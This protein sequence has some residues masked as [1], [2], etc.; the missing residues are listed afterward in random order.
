MAI[1]NAFVRS[2]FPAGFVDL[3]DQPN[4][5][6]RSGALV[7]MDFYTKLTLAGHC[8]QVRL[9]KITTPVTGDGTAITDTAAE[10]A[11]DAP[12]ASVLI[13]LYGEISVDTWTADDGEANFQSV[14]VVS[15]AGTAFT[16]LPLLMNGDAASLTTAR[17]AATGAVTVTAD[18]VTTTRQHARWHAQEGAAEADEN[19]NSSDATYKWYPRQGADL[20]LPGPS[21]LYLQVA[22][23]TY[24][25]HID[26]AEVTAASL[27]L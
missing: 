14:G 25:A 7:I 10:I 24:M 11:I 22:L 8:F 5:L 19:V 12:A 9:G 26:Y 4:Q 23:W 13:P 21:C 1:E 20:F 3:S 27:G 16:P 2:A 6:D 15:S 18:A 17:A